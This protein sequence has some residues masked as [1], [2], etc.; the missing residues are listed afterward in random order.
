MQFRSSPLNLIDCRR[1]FIEG[2]EVKMSIGVYDHE[3]IAKQRVI[4]NVDLYVPLRL[5]TPQ[6]DNLNEVLDY[7]FICDVIN[8]HALKEHVQL[9][10]TLCDDIVNDL[11]AHPK[12]VAVRVSTSKPDAYAD[13]LTVGVESFQ[14]KP[15]F[16]GL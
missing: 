12:V 14:L 5:N 15:K 13:C 2:Y 3:K 10:E 11:I 9:Q 4:F 7:Q 6:S 16:D 8:I 1:I